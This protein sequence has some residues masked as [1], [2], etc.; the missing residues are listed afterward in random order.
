MLR[1]ATGTGF[2]FRK[3]PSLPLN[4]LWSKPSIARHPETPVRIPDMCG[5]K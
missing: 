3:E 2:S 5:P 1:V 4:N